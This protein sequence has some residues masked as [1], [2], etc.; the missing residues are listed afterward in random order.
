[1][2][3]SVHCNTCII[4][5][6]YVLIS[7]IPEVSLDK[8]EMHETWHLHKMSHNNNNVCVS[9]LVMSDSLQPHEHVVHGILQARILEWI[10]MPFSR[11]S[12]RPR[13]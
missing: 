7:L 8:A 11:G 6:I 10:A 2:S 13:D 5:K 3:T 9:H 4:L 1:M 12:S